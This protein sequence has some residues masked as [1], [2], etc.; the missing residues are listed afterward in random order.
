ME[1][2]ESPEVWKRLPGQPSV[3]L[4]GGITGC[5][6]WQWEV[7]RQLNMT[8]YAVLNPRRKTFVDTRGAAELQIEWEFQHLRKADL[9]AFWFCKETVQPIAL[10]ELGAW[11][12]GTDPAVLIGVELG[13]PRA[14]DIHIQMGLLGRGGIKSTLEELVNEI[15]TFERSIQTR[16]YNKGL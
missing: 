1:Y 15:K 9:I 4:A 14:L 3:F 2:V 5:P 11:S 12:Q 8:N 13:Y 10:F 7:A 6:N 16:V